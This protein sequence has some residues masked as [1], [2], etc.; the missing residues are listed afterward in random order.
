M[1]SSGLF[2]ELS[3][4]NSSRG[5]MLSNS[6][7]DITRLRMLLDEHAP[8]PQLVC[9]KAGVILKAVLD[10]LTQLYESSL[11]RHSRGYT[12]GDLLP[13]IDK[14]LR[15]A[16]KIERLTIDADGNRCYQSVPLQPYFDEL[17]KIMQVRNI[18]G[19]HFN[20]LSSDLLDADALRFGE[21]VY[22]LAE[23]L[24]DQEVGWPRSAKSGEYWSTTGGSRRLYPLR[25]PG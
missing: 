2:I 1:V 16:L 6:V 3:G 11:P 19:C 23:H 8:D 12:L 10:F 24:L 14:K 17:H 21:Q 4:W 15:P 20:Q 25:K 22:E 13:A 5:V 18:F 7:T 9:A